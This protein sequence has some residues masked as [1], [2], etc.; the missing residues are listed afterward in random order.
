MIFHL[1]VLL[2]LC[3]YTL[4]VEALIAAD[5]AGMTNG[6]F[7]FIVIIMSPMS[8]RQKIRAPFKLFFSPYNYRGSQQKAVKRAFQ[9]TLILGPTI[10]ESQEVEQFEKQVISESPKAPFFSKAYERKYNGKYINNAVSFVSLQMLV[11]KSLVRWYAK[12]GGEECFTKIH[13]IQ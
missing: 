6:E 5:K 3:S 8:L 9:T 12:D 11:C 13:C 10:S 2:F 1:S 7:V 4:S